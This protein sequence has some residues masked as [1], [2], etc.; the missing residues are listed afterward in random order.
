ME[1]KEEQEKE[2]KQPLGAPKKARA[3]F[4]GDGAHA[5]PEANDTLPAQPMTALDDDD[6]FA[7]TSRTPQGEV[8]S[9]NEE[10][11][12]VAAPATKKRRASNLYHPGCCRTL[13][14][15]SLRHIITPRT[16]P[17]GQPFLLR[18]GFCRQPRRKTLGK[19][20]RLTTW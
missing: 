16:S 4:I 2:S 13:L 5:A 17:R 1:E 12:H 6:A 20:S 9:D 7:D 3:P 18:N 14:F 19:S 11:A 8:E 15:S 10:E